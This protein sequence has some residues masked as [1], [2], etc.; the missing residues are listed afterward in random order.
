MSLQKVTIPALQARKGKQKFTMLTA[1]DAPFARLVDEA[2]IDVILVGDS[3][4]AVVLGYGGTA[5]VTMDEMIHHAKAV[6]RTARHALLVG[7]MPF[8]SYQADTAEAVRNAGRHIKEAGMDC[9]K[10]EG[11]A[12][13]APIARA[14]VDAGIAVIG[15]IGLTLQT[16]ASLGG[17]V[18][19]GGGSADAARRILDDALAMEAAGCWAVLMEAVPADLGALIT[20]RLKVPTIGI[21]AGPACDGQVLLTHE[22][23]G[24]FPGLG[25]PWG[26]RYLDAGALMSQAIRQYADDIHGG[27]FPGPENSFPLDPSILRE[28]EG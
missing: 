28:L 17:V 2:G 22:M 4:G 1:Y 5:P 26:N 9:V 10:L 12:K 6:G 14:I 15:H 11:S 7:D 18:V 27:T 21:G 20:R 19:Q 13:Q 24:L 3:L 16:A 23:L 8:M 25:L